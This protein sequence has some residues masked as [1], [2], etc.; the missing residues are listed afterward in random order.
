RHFLAQLLD[1]LTALADHHARTGRVD[2]DAGGLGR[3]LDQDLRNARLGELLAQHLPDLHVRGQVLRVLAL[4]GEPLR[5]PVLGDAKADTGRMNFVTHV[6]V[7]ALLAR[8]HNHGDV[9]GALEDAGAA[10]LGA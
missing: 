8:A 2:G 5:V 10:A 4:V 6:V 7:P 9:A 3:T 1:V